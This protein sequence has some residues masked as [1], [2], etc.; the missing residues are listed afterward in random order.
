SFKFTSALFALLYFGYK[1]SLIEEQKEDFDP[2]SLLNVE[3]DTTT[4]DIRKAYRELSK[5][6]HPDSKLKLSDSPEKF[7]ALTKAYKALTNPL[8]RE[9]FEKY[10]HPDGPQS[11][12]TFFAI[13]QWFVEKRNYWKIF[14]RVKLS[15]FHPKLT[16][17]YCQ[18]SL[19]LIAAHIHRLS[20]PSPV[21][22]SQLKVVLLLPDL[23]RVGLVPVLSSKG[24]KETTLKAVYFL[25]M[26]TQA[27]KENSSSLEM[28]PYITSDRILERVAFG[29]LYVK[30]YCTCFYEE[31]KSRSGV[32][33]I[34]EFVQ[35]PLES[36]RSTL[37]FKLALISEALHLPYLKV[38]GKIG[39]DGEGVP[40]GSV[41]TVVI[42]IQR[43][44]INEYISGRAKESKAQTVPKAKHTNGKPPFAYCPHFPSPLRESWLVALSGPRDEGFLCLPQ[45][46]DLLHGKA[47]ITTCEKKVV[48]ASSYDMEETESSQSSDV[49]AIES[50]SSEVEY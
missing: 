20:L 34:I 4:A 33:A 18:K 29:A 44:T 48:E 2:Y 13:P 38:D 9:N 39:S 32:S 19:A 37:P 15:S 47:E 46:V 41:V 27:L 36:K 14:R 1:V 12:N 50:D 6:Y 24:Y 31:F 3:V 35:I 17:S 16:A 42:Y 10:G 21:L 43:T 25:Q 45:F 49:S 26:V 7:M 8:A 22:S 30:S 11:L 40:V 23:V 28:L 5:R